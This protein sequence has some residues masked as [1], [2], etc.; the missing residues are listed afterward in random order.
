LLIRFEFWQR[1]ILWGC[2]QWRSKKHRGRPL[3][4]NSDAQT[5]GWNSEIQRHIKKATSSIQKRSEEC[6]RKTFKYSSVNIRLAQIILTLF[7]ANDAAARDFKFG[8]VGSRWGGAKTQM[9][10]AGALAAAREKSSKDTKITIDSVDVSDPAEG[11]AAL[12]RMDGKEDAIIL[13]AYDSETVKAAIKIRKANGI[14]VVLC[15]GAG[16]DSEVYAVTGTDNIRCGRRLMDELAKQLSDE[17]PVAIYGGDNPGNKIFSLRVKGAKDE[18]AASFPKVNILEVLYRP[19]ESVIEMM[20]NFPVSHPSLRGW[21]MV[22]DW[23]IL[24]AAPGTRGPASPKIAVVDPDVENSIKLVQS[25]D[26]QVLLVQ[27]FFG[28]GF[29][30]VLLLTDTS[31]VKDP[32][33]NFFTKEVTVVT[34]QN[35]ESFLEQWHQQLPNGL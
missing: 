15:G 9:I 35:A 12:Q 27:D 16:P 29:Q 32:D 20:Q 24:P 17:G 21:L 11:V 7:L 5:F 6:M 30:S 31:L 33:K 13:A 3:S 2:V 4:N 8:L 23:G 1:I 25:G 18:Q 14:P 22:V 28:W 26:I 34:S 10:K 19:A